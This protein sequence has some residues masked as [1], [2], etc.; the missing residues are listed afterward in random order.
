[1]LPQIRLISSAN[2]TA[3]QWQ[4][5]ANAESFGWYLTYTGDMR[6]YAVL[7]LGG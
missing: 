7:R 1:M 2:Y 6:G 5:P 3:H 4:P